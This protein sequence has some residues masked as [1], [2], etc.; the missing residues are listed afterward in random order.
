M[1]QTYLDCEVPLAHLDVNQDKQLQN[2]LLSIIDAAFIIEII[3]LLLITLSL[4][5]NFSALTTATLREIMGTY[6]FIPA[7]IIP[8]AVL[9][10]LCC[11]LS[12]IHFDYMTLIKHKIKPQTESETQEIQLKRKPYLS[13]LIASLLLVSLGIL[14]IFIRV[15][16]VIYYTWKTLALPT[17][18]LAILTLVVCTQQRQRGS[19]DAHISTLNS[20]FPANNR[21]RIIA[22]TC[23]IMFALSVPLLNPPSATGGALSFH[24]SRTELPA[25]SLIA[26]RC[27]RAEAPDNTAEAAAAM[28]GRQW[29]EMDVMV[30]QDKRLFLLHDATLR[31]LTDVKDVFPGRENDLSGSFTL[32][33][34]TQLNTGLNWV[35]RD[36]MGEARKLDSSTL[37]VYSAAM[38]PSLYDAGTAALDAGVGLFIDIK[39]VDSIASPEEY[40]QLLADAVAAL[41]LPA[42]SPKVQFCGNSAVMD[43]LRS[44]GTWGLT[45]GPDTCKQWGDICH[46]I[47]VPL[48]ELSHA[49]EVSGETGKPVG[50][51]TIDSKAL[52]RQLWLQGV[53]TVT[54]DKP[55]TMAGIRAPWT[56]GWGWVTVSLMVIMSGFLIPVERDKKKATTPLIVKEMRSPHD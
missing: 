24:I 38:V 19:A 29:V 48:W 18:L 27:G 28:A 17:A 23:A 52:Y 34:L 46:R 51:W 15:L 55:T 7:W 6:I 41:G 49:L 21:D 4:T 13:T 9:F 30:S 54:S 5:H 11:V 26:H 37:D 22:I 25:P 43:S 16:R 33:E 56:V 44:L 2:P 20:I 40:A 39:Q 42:D 45:T 36:P 12:Q 31:H 50:V 14:S 32:S 10:G 8:F 35:K 1:T 3:F 53:D 47:N